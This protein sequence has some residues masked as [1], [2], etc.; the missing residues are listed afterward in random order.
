MEI[1]FLKLRKQSTQ[2]ELWERYLAGD[3]TINTLR[4]P[5]KYQHLVNQRV[6]PKVYVDAPTME[7]GPKFEEEDRA[8]LEQWKKDEFIKMIRLDEKSTCFRLECD[9]TEFEVHDMR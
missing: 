1:L 2:V 8:I 4:D 6:E 5:G 7:W 3:P 9:F